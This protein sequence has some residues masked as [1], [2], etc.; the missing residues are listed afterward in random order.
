MGV[1]ARAGNSQLL[2][3]RPNGDRILR[4]RMQC[5]KQPTNTKTKRSLLLGSQDLRQARILHHQHRRINK[6]LSPVPPTRYIPSS[7][8]HPSPTITNTTR[9][10]QIFP[11]L[12]I[13]R[14]P[15][16]QP[17]LHTHPLRPLLR[18]RRRCRRRIPSPHR[19]YLLH[20]QR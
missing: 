4:L 9:L 7:T 16:L 15:P 3:R 5:P 14:A 6:T 19:L 11:S 18:P 2:R 12:H 8:S 17:T 1:R 10:A 20:P 13:P